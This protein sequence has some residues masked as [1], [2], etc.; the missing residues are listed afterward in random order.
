MYYSQSLNFFHG[1]SFFSFFFF[2]QHH[3][4]RSPGV[5]AKEFDFGAAAVAE[6]ES[7]GYESDGSAILCK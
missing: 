7:R 6:T 1:N 5:V 3:H 4:L 2:F